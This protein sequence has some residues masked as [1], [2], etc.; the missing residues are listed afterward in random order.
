[1]RESSRTAGP[2]AVMNDGS[3]MGEI[4]TSANDGTKGVLRNHEA[5]DRAFE[6]GFDR[7]VSRPRGPTDGYIR[8][9]SGAASAGARAMPCNARRV[10]STVPPMRLSSSR[11]CRAVFH[12][13]FPG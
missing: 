11:I 8:R 7:C 13:L 10:P 5:I 6:V 2:V 3:T 9:R 1:M 4:V 12:D